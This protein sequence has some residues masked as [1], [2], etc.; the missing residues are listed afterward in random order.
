MTTR[1]H[2][3]EF[4]GY[5]DVEDGGMLPAGDPTEDPRFRKYTAPKYTAPTVTKKKLT[6]KQTHALALLRKLDSLSNEVRSPDPSAHYSLMKR[7]KQ[8]LLQ[9]IAEG[10]E[11]KG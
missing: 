4:N 2:L 9:E 6:E 1:Y 5:M 10:S 11:E 3:P 7:V 8:I